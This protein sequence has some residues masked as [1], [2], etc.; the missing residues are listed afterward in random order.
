MEALLLHREMASE[1][2]CEMKLW[3]QARQ[4]TYN[5]SKEVFVSGDALA[6]GVRWGRHRL[7][8]KALRGYEIPYIISC[9]CFFLFVFL[10]NDCTTTGNFS[11]SLW[12][13]HVI[14]N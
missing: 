14:Y 6:G 5:S 12:R 10:A 2:K 13:H 7:A 3:K 1:L 9:S 8:C 4:I 11:W